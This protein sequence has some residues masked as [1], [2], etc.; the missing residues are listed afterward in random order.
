LAKDKTLG[1]SQQGNSST[2]LTS[3]DDNDIVI[4][5]NRVRKAVGITEDL[6]WTDEIA[7][8]GK[9]T[10]KY[11]ENLYWISGS[12]ES[13][14]GAVSAWA[15]EK[16]NYKYETNSCSGMCGHYTQIVWR[17]TKFVDCA[18]AS[19][20]QDGPYGHIGYTQL[21]VCNYHPAGNYYC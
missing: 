13:G 1:D 10:Q 15:S 16:E 7:R 17:D 3:E 8:S 14:A 2:Q 4:T 11:G 9:Y 20:C 19:C 18:I 5:Y 12:T 6:Q 21:W